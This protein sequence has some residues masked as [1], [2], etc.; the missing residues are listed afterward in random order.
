MEVSNEGQG[1]D[2]V[3]TWDILGVT[4]HGGLLLGSSY[5]LGKIVK[6]IGRSPKR[7]TT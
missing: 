4:A 1:G 6:G 7:T 3:W 5:G 2:G